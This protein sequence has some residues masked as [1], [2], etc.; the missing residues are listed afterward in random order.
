MFNNFS[1]H[2]RKQR[3]FSDHR[4]Q[5]RKRVTPTA[6]GN[7][8]RYEY[9]KTDYLYRVRS[10]PGYLPPA[11]FTDDGSRW[12]RQGWKLPFLSRRSNTGATNGWALGWVW[13]FVCRYC[14]GSANRY[15]PPTDQVSR[16]IPRPWKLI[17]SFPGAGWMGDGWPWSARGTVDLFPPRM[18]LTINFFFSIICGWSFRENS[19][20]M[21]LF[22][23]FRKGRS[24]NKIRKDFEVW[25]GK[26]KQI[27]GTCQLLC[28]ICRSIQKGWR[29]Y[30]SSENIIANLQFELL[31]THWEFIPRNTADNRTNKLR[32]NKAVLY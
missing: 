28:P 20:L 31:I 6:E 23:F 30:F 18:P 3:N 16:E 24:A 21:V 11:P 25:G 4:T 12:T 26:S 17:Q 2:R 7:S 15:F 5:T 1:F 29:M 14:E 9:I 27:Y 8:N 22:F 13:L 10:F 19:Q 32:K